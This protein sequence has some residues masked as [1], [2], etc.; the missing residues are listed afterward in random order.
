LKVVPEGVP[1]PDL[2]GEILG[3]FH[4]LSERHVFDAQQRRAYPTVAKP[5]E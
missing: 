4:S 5:L 1:P 3:H 2:F